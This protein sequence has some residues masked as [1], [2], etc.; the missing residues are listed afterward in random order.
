M[1]ILKKFEKQP[2]ETKYFDVH[3]E[4]F[5]DALGTTSLGEPLVVSAEGIVQTNPAT[6]TEGVVRVWAEGGLTD[7]EYLYTIKVTCVSGWIEEQEIV[8]VVKEKP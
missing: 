8:V 6:I 1:A 7:E 2:G 5:L 4:K 3:F